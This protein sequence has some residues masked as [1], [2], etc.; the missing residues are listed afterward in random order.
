MLPKVHKSVIPGRSICSSIDHPTNRISSFI[1]E[2]IE[3]YVPLTKSYVRHTHHFISKVLNI[4]PLLT[5][6]ILVTMDVVSLY[7]NI[8]NHEAVMSVSNWLLKDETK[9]DVAK[10]LL[11]LLRLILY[12]TNFT[13]N[14]DHY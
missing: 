3:Q 7:T 14:G 6:S 9:K 10:P 8:P 11:E 12:N 4:P 5:G 13:V 1:D 2:H